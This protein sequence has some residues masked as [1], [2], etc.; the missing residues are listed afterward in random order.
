ML[1]INGVD[2]LFIRI[3]LSHI[4]RFLTVSKITVKWQVLYCISFASYHVCQIVTPTSTR[5]TQLIDL[6]PRNYIHCYWHHCL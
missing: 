5:V 1:S 2:F 4:R 3:V 6:T